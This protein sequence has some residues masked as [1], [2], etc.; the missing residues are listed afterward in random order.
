MRE[1]EIVQHQ[2]LTTPSSGLSGTQLKIAGINNPEEPEKYNNAEVKYGSTFYSRH[3]GQQERAKCVKR[4]FSIICLTW[5]P[6]AHQTVSSD[7]TGHRRN[8]SNTQCTK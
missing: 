2:S 5:Q 4:S 6:S 8:Q 7:Q 3:S 1:N